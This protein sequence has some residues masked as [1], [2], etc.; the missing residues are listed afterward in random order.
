MN[1]FKYIFFIIIPFTVFG[2]KP[3][4]K[5]LA[6]QLD[7][8]IILGKEYINS[9]DFKNAHGIFLNVDSLIIKNYGN[10]SQK[11]LEVYYYLARS[12]NKLQDSE[13]A[14]IQYKKTIEL[15]KFYNDTLSE[16]Y[17]ISL[18]ELSKLFANHGRFKEAELLMLDLF[19][20]RNLKYGKLHPKSAMS[21][22]SL[23]ILNAK[24]ENYELATSYGIECLNIRE[25]VFGKNSMEY[26]TTVYHL[27]KLYNVQN[28][29]DSAIHYLYENLQILRA[30]KKTNTSIYADCIAELA[31]LMKDR[32]ADFE[33]A[34]ALFQES[35][36]VYQNEPKLKARPSY[37][38]L[39]KGLGIH[40]KSIGNFNKALLYLYEAKS[41]T[42]SSIGTK[43]WDYYSVL[44]NIGN[45]YLEQKNFSAAKEMYMFI[46]NSDE[47]T[48]E[49]KEINFPY[50]KGALI[51][52]GDMTGENVPESY[53]KDIM[54]KAR[55]SETTNYTLA[56]TLNQ[57]SVWLYN[58]HRYAEA[59]ESDREALNIANGVYSPESD[60]LNGI[61]FNLCS[62]YLKINQPD[63]AR[64]YFFLSYNATKRNS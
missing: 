44:Y 17:E 5:I 48:A 37:A 4:E 53:A 28:H 36:E 60:L 47:L 35:Y 29:F 59:L 7:S 55:S 58:H 61:Y 11:Y 50:V 42:K 62:D 52:L 13:E 43:N 10:T 24:I 32:F 21:I 49:D 23:S 30:L 2:Q 57:N 26:A 19:K 31:F 14:I 16:N 63:S 8:M 39:L 41:A 40:Y 12:A 54:T 51:S 6:K 45:V 22:Y 20:L 3:A 38:L 25:A 46:L 33:Q 18:D 56:M 64:K 15:S 34:E 9:N 27:V 1:S